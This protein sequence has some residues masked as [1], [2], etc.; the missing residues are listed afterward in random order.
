MPGEISV[1]TPIMIKRPAAFMFVGFHGYQG[2][3]SIFDRMLSFGVL[4][5][6]GR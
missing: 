1:K 6:L 5:A 3:K 4:F 2:Y